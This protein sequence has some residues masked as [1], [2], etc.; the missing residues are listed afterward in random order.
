VQLC[1][2]I[3]PYVQATIRSA[4]PVDTTNSTLLCLV[5]YYTR[6]SYVLYS[7]LPCDTTLDYPLYYA[8]RYY[9]RLSAL[10]CLPLYFAGR[11]AP[12]VEPS[13]FKALGELLGVSANRVDRESRWGSSHQ[14]ISSLS[15]G[16]SLGE[17][18]LR[19]LL[20]R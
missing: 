4:L 2:A 12:Y 7:T 1:L 5:I 6:L 11:R 16:E 13:S 20:G 9:N 19:E 8:C 18:L 14:K 3:L 15:L 10:H 17:S